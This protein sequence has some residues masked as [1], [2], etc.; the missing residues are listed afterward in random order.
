MIDPMRVLPFAVLLGAAGPALAQTE[1][2]DAL[3]IVRGIV[4]DAEAG[5]PSWALAS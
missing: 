4:R 2:T 5:R 1:G 3:G